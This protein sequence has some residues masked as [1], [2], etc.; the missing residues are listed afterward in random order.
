MWRTT[1]PRSRRPGYQDSPMLRPV[2]KLAPRSAAPAAPRAQR[3]DGGTEYA[4]AFDFPRQRSLSP[5][6]QPGVFQHSSF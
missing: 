3:C 2:G 4:L 6:L 5:D 1:N